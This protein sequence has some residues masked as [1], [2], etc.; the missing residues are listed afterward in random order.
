[1]PDEKSF[2][3]EIITPERDFFSGECESLVV[4]TVNGE[5]GILADSLPLAAIL[6]DGGIRIRQKNKWMKAFTGTGFIK[7][8]KSGASVLVRSAE[9]PYEIKESD[10]EED[11]GRLKEQLKKK[12]SVKEYKMAKAELARQLAR[13]RVKKDI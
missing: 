9:W 4:T 10:A 2:K 3:L 13:L 1:M 12:Q 7:V 8:N 5:M 6:A 11:I